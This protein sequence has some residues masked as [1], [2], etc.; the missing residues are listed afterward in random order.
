[1]AESNEGIVQV[2]VRELWHSEPYNFTPWL[3]D[4]LDMLAE[5][6]GLKLELVQQEKLIGSMFL[7]VLAKDACSGAPVAIENQLEWSDTDHMG[8]LL[9]YAAGCEAKVVI[10]VAS[11]FMHEHAQVLHQLNEWA[12]SNASFYAVKVEAIKK[13]DASDHEPRLVKVVWP[14]GWDKAI[15]LDIVPPPRPEVQQCEEFFR[16]L[17]VKMLGA[18][19]RFAESYGNAWWHRDRFFP[20]AFHK[21]IGY[22]AS[23]ERRVACVYLLL[24]TWS[25]VDLNNTLFDALKEEQEQFQSAIDP[26]ANWFWN[27]HSGHTFSTIGVQRRASIDDP[28]EKLEETRAWMIEMLPKFKDVFEGRLESLLTK[29]RT[30][31]GNGAGQ[32]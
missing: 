10:W 14:G 8:R 18:E 6:I 16:P 17:I 23:F 32:A 3:A 15:T 1:M 21:D 29:L 7:D 11:E 4:H 28:P 22:V 12:G 19:P 20:S 13:G 30:P 26:K 27:R 25:S 5:A 24:R 9:I 2:D 31:R